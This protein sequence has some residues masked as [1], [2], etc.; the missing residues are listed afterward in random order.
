LK[1]HGSLS[2]TL[3]TRPG[4]DGLQPG[5]S[6]AR[7]RVNGAQAGDV[8]G[9]F[10]AQG[11]DSVFFATS[12]DT[13]LDFVLAPNSEIG[14]TQIPILGELRFSTI[15]PRTSVE[16]A[17]LLPGK[18]EILFEKLGNKVTLDAADLLVVIPMSKFYLRQFAIKEGIQ[19]SFHGAVQDVRVGAGTSDL[20]TRMPSAFDQLDNAKR[21][22]G[23]IP[24]LVALILGV[25]EKMG[26]LGKK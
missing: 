20:R 13:R 5:F 21:I 3:T 23:V 25:V 24:A 26:G 1:A 9:S 16:K 4:E 8:E 12:S 7:V 2:G 6:C 19:L 17:V 14:D 10:S 22:Y 15:D 11:G 18:N